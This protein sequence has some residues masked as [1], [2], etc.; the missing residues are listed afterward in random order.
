MDAREV[1][2]TLDF[3]IRVGELLIASGTGAADAVATMGQVSRALGLRNCDIDVTFV[4]VAMQYQESAD[5]PPV[6]ANRLVKARV[7]DYEH[8]TRVDHLIREI[9]RG[10]LDIK[11]ARLYLGRITS[12]GHSRPRWA[13]TLGLAIMAAAVAVQLGGDL[14][15][16]VLAFV[17]AGAI[18][19]VQLV[20]SRR[21]IP[22]FYQQIAGA[23]VATVLAVGTASL[24]FAVDVS[25]AIT[26]NIVVLLAGIGL[27][28]ALQDA[29]AGFYITA[30]ARILEALLST[31]GII[32]GVSGGLTLAATVGVDIPRIQ[33]GETSLHSVSLTVA[34][35]ALGASAFAYSCYAPRRILLPIAVVAAGAIGIDLAL[36]GSGRAWPVACAAFAIGLVSYSVAG[37]MRVPPLV[38]IVPAVVPML[39]GLSIYRG[40]T[41]LLT[42]SAADSTSAGLLEMLTALTIAVALAAGVILGEY[43]AQPLRRGGRRLE[44][45][46]AGP[47][48]VGPVARGRG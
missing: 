14:L 19:R 16:A 22:V 39:P 45:R 47:R 9:V 40:L 43:V 15:V 20:L 11:T 12:T 8:L 44:A 38:V 46:L 36:S 21:R 37:R 32:A 42:D 23:G 28:G 41:L 5:Q 35:A 3:C 6:V 13:A 7:I 27:M 4:T 1:N 34:G 33:P 18:D 25:S 2:L 26:A 24:P 29:L 30:N 17:S 10:E 31:A 48:L